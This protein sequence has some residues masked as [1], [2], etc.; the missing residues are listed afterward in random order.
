MPSL[1]DPPP[2]NAREPRAHPRSSPSGDDSWI[3]LRQRCLAAGACLKPLGFMLGEGSLMMLNGFFVLPSLHVLAQVFMI[4]RPALRLRTRP[5][6]P[7]DLVARFWLRSFSRPCFSWPPDGS[8][9]P[10]GCRSA[11]LEP[12]G[13]CT[14]ISVSLTRVARAP[15][16]SRY[17]TR[18][19]HRGAR[20]RTSSTL[21]SRA[22]PSRL[23]AAW[24]SCAV[25]PCA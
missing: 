7:A 2:Q 24:S 23:E 19:H 20:R 17:G 4:F 25:D 22:S 6:P 15:H 18:P 14:D 3:G 16:L 21:G 12:K 13:F 11:P 5:F 10:A 8:P 9:G 1:E